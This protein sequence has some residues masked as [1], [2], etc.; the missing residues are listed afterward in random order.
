[1]PSHPA[2]PEP[3]QYLPPHHH[4]FL[5]S[6]QQHP[7]WSL[8]Q[9]PPLS[10]KQHPPLSLKQHPPWLLKQHPPLSLKQHPGCPSVDRSS[11]PA[12]AAIIGFPDRYPSPWLC[13]CVLAAVVIGL[14][15][16]YPSRRPPCSGSSSVGEA[17]DERR[18]GGV[19]SAAA[20]AAEEAGPEEAGPEEEEGCWEG[21]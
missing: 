10:L 16:R 14:P 11:G 9:H 13:C 5:P 3:T 4:L 15:H 20:A 6:L 19:G 21:S 7:P 17:P 8:K 1:M 2:D 12:P 18:K